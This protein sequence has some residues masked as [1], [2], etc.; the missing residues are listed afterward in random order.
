[1]FNHLFKCAHELDS[2]SRTG[3]TGY[4]GGDFL[5]LAT[6]T[7]PDWQFTCLIRDPAKASAITAKYNTVRTV[8][9]NLDA[10]D[11]I[12]A[13]AAAANIIYHFADC[14]HVP[15]ANAIAKG[16]SRNSNERVYWIHT[17]GTGI[18]TFQNMNSNSYG[19][20]FPNEKVYNDWDGIQD[21]VSLPDEAL[22][23]KVDKIVLAASQDHENRIKTAIV[24][25][26]T[27]YG[28]G[29][30]TGNKTSIQVNMAANL[31]LR[32]GKAM[33]IGDGSSVWH[34]VHVHD[35]SQ[36]YLLLGEAAVSGNSKATWNESGYYFVEN[37]A[38]AWGDVILAIANEA[39]KQGLL[40][41]NEVKSLDLEQA[42]A[43]HP[44]YPY[45]CGTTS[46]GVSKRA[47][48]VLG[49]APKGNSLMEELPQL[50]AAEAKVPA[51]VAT[52]I[53]SH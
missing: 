37:G 18:L 34:E 27:I 25:P 6:E 17:S 45:L 32:E 28:V 33:Q 49:W 3:A 8:L 46:R 35:L 23:R 44:Y 13:E 24:C 10:V 14:D 36:L 9:G 40:A 38:F 15:S 53:R 20:A 29:R 26:P 51:L 50:I 5:S 1:M 47:G 31:A 43:V 42:Q 52:Q 39:H 2:V 4:I 19:F 22:H 41:T 12:E 7:H 30:G 11:I 48:N 16:I 21:L